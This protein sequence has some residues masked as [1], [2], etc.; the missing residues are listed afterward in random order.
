MKKSKKALDSELSI[1]SSQLSTV[2]IVVLAGIPFLL[3]R[4]F[5]LNYPD[6]FDSAANVYSAQHIL[7]GARIG[8]DEHPSAALGTLLVNIL[9]V[10]LFGF[11][12]FGPKMIQAIMQAGAFVVMYMAMKKLFG[13]LPAAVGVIVAAIYTS[14]PLVAKF[15]N[16]KEQFMIACMVTGICL[17]VLR[18]LGGGW[19]YSFLA[20]A[21]VSWAPLFKETGSSAI[22]AIGLFVLLQPIFG[23]RTW[24]QTGLDIVLLLAGAVAALAPLYIWIIGWKVQM[25][26]PYSFIWDA[27]AGLVP[28]AQAA[29][30]TS[31]YVSSLRE[32]ISFSEQWPKVLRFYLALCLPVSLAA[33]SIV[34]W[35][36]KTVT[37][38]V[39]NAYD[40]FVLLFGVW[41]LLDMA[42]VWVS[43]A[44]YEQYYLPLTA[45][46]A[47]TGC[48]LTAVYRDKLSSAV[49][50][51]KWIVTGIVGLVLMVVMSWHIFF[52][53]P[54]S[55]YSGMKY[56]EKRNGYI[57]RWNE[58][59]RRKN[60][61]WRGPWERAGEYIRDRTKPSDKIY[62]WGWVPAVY[63][64]AQR[65]CPAPNAFESEMH[66][67]P[68]EQLERLIDELL[69]CFNKEMPKYI[70]DSRKQHLPMDRFKF[71]LWP[72]VPEG[73]MGFQKT[74]FLPNEPNIVAEFEK[75]WGQV[76]RVRSGELEQRRFEIM[77]KFRKFIRD[78]YEIVEMFG[79]EVVFKLKD[80]K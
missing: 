15:G 52:G 14:A 31:T 6:P 49:F 72:I 26:L 40:R 10:W 20:G 67:R 54:R 80:G 79:D 13:K 30:Q 74:Q 66:A 71:E 43:P 24:K 48:Y 22:G 51:T 35:L 45:S 19:W 65:F 8:I 47:A 75:L 78:N 73:F 27:V 33:G 77:G 55:P 63:L 18:Q 76:T 5:E 57:Q 36:G 38:S 3:G 39:S 21:I 53:L 70:V 59:S 64:S 37:K 32:T 29:G 58:I 23:H 62:V 1:L 46:G 25:A 69:S 28:K 42:F 44:S 41:W 11:R 7:N 61:S 4:Y 34:V 12:E 16:V 60:Q 17:F 50:K 2:L 9:G 68:P 56:P